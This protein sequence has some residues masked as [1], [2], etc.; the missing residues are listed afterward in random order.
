MRLIITH[1]D[2]PELAT[3]WSRIPMNLLHAMREHGFEVHP[4]A[5]GR[6]SRLERFGFKVVQRLRGSDITYS[7]IFRHYARRRLASAI[8]RVKPEAVIHCGSTA[9]IPI[10]GSSVRHYLYCDSTWH[11]YVTLSPDTKPPPA[12]IIA[13]VDALE[14]EAYTRTSH[15]FAFSTAAKGDL[16]GY[17]G[18]PPDKISVVGTGCGNVAPYHGPKDYSGGVILYVALRAPRQKGGE[19]LLN[20]FRIAVAKRPSLSL[21]MEGGSIPAELAAGIPNVTLRG[22][23]GREELQQLF[24]AACLYAMPALFEPWGNVYIEALSSRTPI[25]GLNRQSLPDIT[26]GGQFGFLVDEPTPEAVA[27]AI[28]DAT[29][30]PVRLSRMGLNGQRHVLANYTWET[31][32]GRIAKR[33]AADAAPTTR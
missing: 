5:C 25:L 30:D 19:L 32:A 24:N 18:V 14:R 8:E 33:I 23:S 10:V 31:V 26:G 15:I 29:S 13:Q 17:F 9:A 1:P 21:V 22:K 16:A 2:K 7:P 12:R 3:T 6:G 11:R 4:V 20:A 27:R 28:L